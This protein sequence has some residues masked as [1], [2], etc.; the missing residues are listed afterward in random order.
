MDPTERIVF[1]TARLRIH[2]STTEPEDVDMYLRLWNHP[3]VMANVGFPRRLGITHERIVAQLEGQPDSD[4]DTRPATDPDK[5]VGP[6]L[7]LASEGA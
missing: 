3:E 1:E 7:D 2:R 5:G 4:V 6:L